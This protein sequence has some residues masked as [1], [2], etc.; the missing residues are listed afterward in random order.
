M[1]KY[2]VLTALMAFAA[3][4]AAIAQTSSGHS[5]GTTAAATQ[6]GP[7]TADKFQQMVASSDMFEMESSRLALEKAKNDQ[8]KQF[9][10]R[11]MQDHQK[12][13][14][15]LMALMQGAPATTGSAGTSG[16]QGSTATTSGSGTSAAMSHGPGGHSSMAMPGGMKMDPKHT[17]MLEQLRNASGDQFDRLYATIQV[18]AHQEAVSLF[19]NY[20]QNGDNPQLK[21]WAQ[22][23]L[24]DLQ[25]HLQ[26]AQKLPGAKQS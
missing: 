19:Q 14:H 5:G 23:T 3:S 20:A 1:K 16:G 11:M 22:K 6:A 2:V 26:E 25:K 9:A 15:E 18:Q 8:V 12:T 13:S 21:Q 24:P 4:P 7:M 10:Q 17:Q